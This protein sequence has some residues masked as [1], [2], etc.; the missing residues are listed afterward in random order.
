MWSVALHKI[1]KCFLGSSQHLIAF[2]EIDLLYT[3]CSIKS[4]SGGYCWIMSEQQ[5][6]PSCC[7]TLDWAVCSAFM[8]PMWRPAWIL[9]CL[10]GSDV[11]LIGF[12]HCIVPLS[13]LCC[14]AVWH[15]VNV[16]LNCFD[17]ELRHETFCSHTFPCRSVMRS[18]PWWTY[19]SPRLLEFPSSPNPAATLCPLL[20]PWLSMSS[21]RRWWPEIS[22]IK[23]MVSAVRFTFISHK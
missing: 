6:C 20:S 22:R 15:T 8:R 7:M 5:T 2:T 4:L 23:H 14:S 18:R 21:P 1:S 13:V 19:T 10:F 11:A 16:R 9:G 17:A 3:G 12:C